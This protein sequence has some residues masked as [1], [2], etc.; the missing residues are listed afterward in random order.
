[1]PLFFACLVKLNLALKEIGKKHPDIN[2]NQLENTIVSLKHIKLLKMLLLNLSIDFRFAELYKEMDNKFY[3][4]TE[5]QKQLCL[6]PV[7]S[8]YYRLS[9]DKRYIALCFEEFI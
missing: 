4:L 1:M 6:H 8:D 7:L 9:F 5:K 2:I 3:S